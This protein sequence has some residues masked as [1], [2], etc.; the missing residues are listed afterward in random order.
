MC[1]P[2]HQFIPLHCNNTHLFL[3]RYPSMNYYNANL[4]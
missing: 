3:I 4:P 2:W 1:H